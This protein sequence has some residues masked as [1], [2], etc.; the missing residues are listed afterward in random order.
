MSEQ[1]QIDKL[2]VQLRQIQSNPFW[3]SRASL[4]VLYANHEMTE[5][6][7]LIIMD[8]LELIEKSVKNNG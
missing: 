6:A 5:N 4:K 3:L 1:D 2:N 7:F 8:R